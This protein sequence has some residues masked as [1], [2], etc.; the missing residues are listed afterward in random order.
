MWGVASVTCLNYGLTTSFKTLNGHGVWPAISGLR[1]C[2]Q[3]Y[4]LMLA[5]LLMR[6]WGAH[7]TSIIIRKKSPTIPQMTINRGLVK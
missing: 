5:M 1:T 7:G 6:V 2:A 3:V 4:A